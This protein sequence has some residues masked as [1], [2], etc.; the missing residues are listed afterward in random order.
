AKVDTVKATPAAQPVT[1]APVK[2]SPAKPTATAKPAAEPTPPPAPEKPAAA[3]EPAR[4][5]LLRFNCG[6][7]HFYTTSKEEGMKA[8]CVLEGGAGY[9]YTSQSAGT[10]ALHRFSNPGKGHFYSCNKEEGMKAGFAYEGVIGYI[11]TSQVTG[12]RPLY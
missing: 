12:T 4:V 2:S 8:N 5:E 3:P 10:A 1:P 7:T 11:H 6:G 9:M